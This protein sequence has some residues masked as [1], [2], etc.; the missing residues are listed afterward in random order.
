MKT[1]TFALFCLLC[2][3]L[4]LAADRK[5]SAPAKVD[6][7]V[8]ETDLCTLTLTPLAEQRLGIVLVEVTRKTVSISRQ[9]GGDIIVPLAPKGET[10]AGYFPLTT[11]TPEELLRLSDQQAVASGEVEKFKIQLDAAQRTFKRAQKLVQEDAGS[12]RAVEDAEVQVRLA[13]QAMEV[14]RSRRSLLGAP[15]ADAIRSGRIWVRVPV[16]AGELMLIDTAKD[17]WVSAVAA[18]PGDSNWVGKPVPAPPSANALAATVDL[19]Y[20]LE[21]AGDALRPGQRVCV[22]APMR[23]AEESLVAPWSAIVHDIHGN[24][25]VYENTAPQ[26]FVRRRVQVAR[27]AGSEA[28]LAS[29]PKL[30]S[31][32]VTD[33]AA[34]LFGTEFGGGK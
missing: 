11:S 34:E 31:K 32:V 22:R 27:V 5:S 7:A 29:G 18:R 23:G 13:E 14:A 10:P 15:V 12:V 6:N 3:S 30:G 19:F 17:A 8:K 26:T 2:P 4:V 9:F 1:I 16:Y 21:G 33:G 25:W 28:V 20:E 24:A